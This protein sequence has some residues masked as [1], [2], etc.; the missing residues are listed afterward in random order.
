MIKRAM[1]QTE[2]LR[3]SRSAFPASAI[4]LALL[5]V[6]FSDLVLRI[7]D[8]IRVMLGVPSAEFI[9]SLVEGLTTSLGAIYFS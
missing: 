4:Y 7:A 2:L 8:W 5:F 6:L 3:I 9:L 1:F